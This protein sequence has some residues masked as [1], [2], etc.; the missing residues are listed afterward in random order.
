LSVTF[1]IRKTIIDYFQPYVLV[2]FLFY[3]ISSISL[4]PSYLK[5]DP[6][7]VV[8]CKYPM[9]SENKVLG[10]GAYKWQIHL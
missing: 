4:L 8:F 9:V 5:T 10:R 6:K 1:G 3:G 2:L 7:S